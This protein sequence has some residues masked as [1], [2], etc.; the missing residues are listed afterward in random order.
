MAIKTIP[1][2]FYRKLF[3]DIKQNSPIK[4][5][6]QKTNPYL[7]CSAWRRDPSDSKTAATR[8]LPETL[9]ARPVAKKSDA[10]N[11]ND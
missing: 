9:P 7:P 1:Q 3:F 5:A 2:S 11:P 8:H 6:Y 4:Y 10:L